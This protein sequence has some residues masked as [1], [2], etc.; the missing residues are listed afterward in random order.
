LSEFPESINP[1]REQELFEKLSMDSEEF[2]HLQFIRY[3]MRQ[4]YKEE[5]SK[6]NN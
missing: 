3:M 1:G 5:K 2:Q 4:I 6:E